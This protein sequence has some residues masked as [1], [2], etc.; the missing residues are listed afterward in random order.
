MQTAPET[1]TLDDR[2]PAEDLIRAYYADFNVR[3]LEGAAARFHPDARIEHIT[4]HSEQGPNG[5][6]VLARL[7][8]TAF[9]DGRLTVNAVRSCG[10]DM[11]DVDLIATGTHTGTLAFASWM[12]RPTHRTVSLHAREFVQI[13]NGL[14]RFASLS[15]DLQDLVRQ[16][17]T[18]DKD[19]LL[20]HAALI[21]E[22]AAQLREQDDTAR[23][24]DLIERLGRQLDAARQVARPYFRVNQ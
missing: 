12:F 20:Q 15:F 17:T 3:R 9:P 7:W 6:L 1:V 10:R 22:L 2:D 4:G 24:R 18:I 14:F 13:E 11:Y 16:L 23:Q 19:R 8:L 21:Q 5:F